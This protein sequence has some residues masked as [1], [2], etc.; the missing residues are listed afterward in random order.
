MHK[1]TPKQEKFCKKYI[2]T[3]G[4]SA[5]YRLAYDTKNMKPETINRA[6]KQLIDN[7]KIAARIEEIQAHHQKRHEVTIDS[8]TAEL[9]QARNLALA[10]EQPAPAVAATMGKARIHGLLVDKTELTGKDGGP[11][12]IAD[13]KAALLRGIVPNP[14][15]K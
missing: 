3:G 11:V 5:A 12:E 9:D 4:A 8:L 1:L 10:T 15:G 2:E 6:A 7:P 14:A 13:A